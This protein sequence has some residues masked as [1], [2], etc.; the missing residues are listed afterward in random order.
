MAGGAVVLDT[1]DP[2]DFASSHL[3]GAVNVG[4]AGRFAEFA[5]DVL[6]PVDEIVLVCDP[7]ACHRGPCP[8]RPHR[9]R[10]RRGLARGRRS[11][12]VRHRRRGHRREPP[13][14][15]RRARTTARAVG[16]VH[17]GPRRAE[18][19]GAGGRVPS[20]SGQPPLV[21][22]DRP[23]RQ[24][25]RRPA[26]RR[27]IARAATGPPSPP[28]SSPATATPTCRSCSA[29]TQP[30]R[31]L[32]T[33]PAWEHRL[34]E[35]RSLLAD[36]SRQCLENSSAVVARVAGT[37]MPSE[38]ATKSRSGSA[39]LE[40]RAGR[41]TAGIGP[42]S[43][44]LEV[45][46]GVGPVVEDDVRDVQALPGLGPERLN[47]VHGAAVRFEGEHGRSGQAT[48]AP[49]ASGSPWPIELPLS[50]SKSWRRGALGG[51]WQVDSGS[52]GL[53]RDDGPFGKQGADRSSHAGGGSA[54]SG[55]FGPRGR[56]EPC[57]LR[58]GAEPLG[59]CFERSDGIVGP[60][61]RARGPRSPPARDRSACPGRRTPRRAAGH[62]RGRGDGARPSAWRRTHRGRRAAPPPASRPRAR[63]RPGNDSPSNL[64]S[65]CSQI[66]LAASSPGPRAGRTCPTATPPA[67]S[68]A[69]GR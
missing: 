27:A 54:P 64:A 10:R 40:H 22:A 4:L 63:K 58:R 7:R 3:A 30:G 43:T 55:S 49:T 32:A 28:A 47:R 2:A 45:Q 48:A 15:R 29:A 42:H 19:L 20:G 62:R 69:A 51:T 44:E 39:D 35:V 60:F 57:A 24:H 68:D 11:G 53:V 12:P 13:N 36:G 25:R 37:P 17:H 56:R 34:D 5:G 33:G 14:H 46:D 61:R 6:R 66:R 31:R 26:G 21:T 38:M 18:P 52:D 59:E 41:R 8:A 1:R 9:L 50:E 23:S 65:A 67:R 16:A